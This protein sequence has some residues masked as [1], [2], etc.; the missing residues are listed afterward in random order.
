MSARRR[1][2]IPAT[3][4]TEAP[5]NIRRSNAK[6]AEII[7]KGSDSNPTPLNPTPLNPDNPH[8][9]NSVISDN[10][11]INSVNS[12]ISGVSQNRTGNQ[13]FHNIPSQLGNPTPQTIPSQFGNSANITPSASGIQ[14]YGVSS[15]DSRLSGSYHHDG[16]KDDVFIIESNANSSFSLR[17]AQLK[18]TLISLREYSNVNIKALPPA[19]TEAFNNVVDVFRLLHGTQALY[20]IILADV[21]DIFKNVKDIRPGTVAA[22]F[23]GCFTDDDFPGSPGC[24]PKCASSLPPPEGSPGHSDCDDLVLIYVNGNFNALNSKK[25]SLAHIFVEDQHFKGFTKNDIQQL[26]DNG[27]ERVVMIFGNPDGSYREISSPNPVSSLPKFSSNPSPADSQV[28]TSSNNDNNNSN[29]VGAAVLLT[30]LIVFLILV[31]L[32][33][34]YRASS[35]YSS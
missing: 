1:S 28:N 15:E 24:N 16:G 5:V 7:F 8:I 25:S 13:S 11:S 10:N 6:N 34:L 23:A 31:I 18:N 33:V 2:T 17:R 3:Q 4:F 9:I 20:D 21:R 32:Y 27:I 29:N 12:A 22:Y 30:I 19:Q 14:S 35:W 26:T